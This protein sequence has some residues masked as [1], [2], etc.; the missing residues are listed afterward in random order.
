M[1]TGR[2]TEYTEELATEIC[3]RIASGESLRSICKDDKMPAR[4]SVHLWLL[5]KNKKGFSDQYELACNIRAENMFDE[6]TE[7]A[8]DGS[9]D[10]MEK[11]VADGRSITVVDTEHISRSRLRVD[12]RKWYL[13][14]VL[15][16]KFG[17]KLD[18]T[19]NGKDL[20]TP[21]LGN[22][23]INDSDKESSEPEEENTGGAGGHLGIE[24]DIDS[25]VAN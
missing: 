23:P 15:P 10:Y 13:S 5:D 4:S 20:P 3:S 22:V 9:N 14:K 25:S 16:K 8:D 17:E 21:I 7:I 11:E 12:T 2:P 19:T 1:P 18:M 24:D 6:L